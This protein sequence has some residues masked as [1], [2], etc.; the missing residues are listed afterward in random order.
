M[1]SLQVLDLPKTLRGTNTLAYFGLPSMTKKQ[2]VRHIF[3]T[4]S[5]HDSVIKCFLASLMIMKMPELVQVEHPLPKNI[6]R[7][8]RP[9]LFWPTMS[10]NKVNFNKIRSFIQLFY[11]VTGR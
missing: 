4:N 1:S 8:K 2:V 5:V 10:D 3:V 9:S 11:V 6:E 7:D